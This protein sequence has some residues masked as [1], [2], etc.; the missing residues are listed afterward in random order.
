[1]SST[2]KLVAALVFVLLQV[3]YGW[4]CYQA[5]NRNGANAV[6]VESQA[7]TIG[8]KDAEISTLEQSIIEHEAKAF[9]LAFAA[10][11]ASKDHEKELR[12]VRAAAVR[13]ADKRVRIDRAAFCGEDGTGTQGSQTGSDGQGNS[14]AAFLP[15]PFARNLR[16]LVAYADEVTADLR[17]LVRRVDEAACFMQ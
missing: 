3:A 10:K 13:D 4:Y 9:G 7:E 12:D 16:Q 1:M 6:K 14:G 2:S 17:H 15:E 5:G 8:R 11:Q